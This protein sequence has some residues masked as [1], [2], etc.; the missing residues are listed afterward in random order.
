MSDESATTPSPFRVL[1]RPRRRP[2]RRATDL[3]G[4]LGVERYAPTA[5]ILAAA[6]AHL[7]VLERAAA[8]PRLQHVSAARLARLGA[9]IR[10]SARLLLDP[11][12]G[13]AYARLLRD[14]R[15]PAHGGIRTDFAA[16]DAAI[17]EFRMAGPRPFNIFMGI[18]ERQ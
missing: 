8:Q 9:C 5:V 17:F 13:L 11:V 4:N 15:L 2:V 7:R 16:L 3:Y 18:G 12:R 14:G 1:D 6:G 10:E